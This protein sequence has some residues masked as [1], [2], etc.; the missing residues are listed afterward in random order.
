MTCFI[1]YQESFVFKDFQCFYAKQYFV[2][3][4]LLSF[5]YSE[6]KANY[7]SCISVYFYTYK[8]LQHPITSALYTTYHRRIMP[9]R[10][11]SR[12][13]FEFPPILGTNTFN[14]LFHLFNIQRFRQMSVHTHGNA[15]FSIF[16]ECI[17]C[18]SYNRYCF[19]I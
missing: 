3:S 7:I 17:C 4:R 12:L 10:M 5:I 13:V 6:L 16:L 9:I 18:H 1:L 8:H 15:L 2:C 11:H 14:S 19:C